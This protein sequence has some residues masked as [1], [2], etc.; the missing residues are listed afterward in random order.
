MA[1]PLRSGVAVEVGLAGVAGMAALLRSGVAEEMILAEEEE[2]AAGR[3]LDRGE[4]GK[5]ELAQAMASTGI[6]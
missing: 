5:A 1:A 2:I 4:T 6:R 3:M